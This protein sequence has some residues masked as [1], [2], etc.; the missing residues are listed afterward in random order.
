MT[1]YLP[2]RAVELRQGPV[3]SALVTSLEDTRTGSLSNG[4]ASAAKI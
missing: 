4:V 3:I 2:Y 1:L